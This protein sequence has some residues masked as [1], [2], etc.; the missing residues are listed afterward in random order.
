M[1]KEKI[2]DRFLSSAKSIETDRSR[3]LRMRYNRNS[4]SE[5]TGMCRSGAITIHEDVHILADNCTECMLCVS[6]CPSDCFDIQS[7]DFHS[8]LVR[9]RRIKNLVPVPVLGCNIKNDLQAHVKTPCLGFLSEEHILSLSVFLDTGLHINMTECGRCKNSFIVDVIEERVKNIK[10]RNLNLPGNI[11]LIND[12]KNLGYGD[13]GYDRRG[14]FSTVKNLTFLQ[15]AEFF[16]RDD[17]VPASQSYS[18]KKIPAKRE[19]LNRILAY[20]KSNNSGLLENYYFT[21]HAS[22][23]CDNCFA[24]VGMCP[25]GALKVE[26]TGEGRKLSFSSALCNGC[27]LCHNF[28]FRG[29]LRIEKGFSGVNPFEYVSL[30]ISTNDRNTGEY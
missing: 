24:C 26:V 17:T 9:L 6:A 7:F 14:F 19:F 4:C 12:G 23:D 20:K 28:C 29:A 25:S 16:E 2:A 8:V 15:A 5:C 27:S 11:S 13:A 1:L 3:C 18:D 21:V 30:H 22:E 10:A